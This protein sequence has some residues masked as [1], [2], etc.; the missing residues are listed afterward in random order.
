MGARTPTAL[1]QALAQDAIQEAS[2]RGTT[3]RCYS[4][5]ADVLDRVAGTRMWGASAYMA[6]DQL[7]ANPKFREVAAPA[8]LRQLPAGAVVVWGRT[9]AS[10]HGH[11]S[12]ALGDGREASDHVDRQRNNLRGHRNARVFVPGG[13]NVT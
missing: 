3:G 9:G 1:G 10:P 11:I 7:A 4:A 12:I 8:D 5:T 2:R 13:A 6:A